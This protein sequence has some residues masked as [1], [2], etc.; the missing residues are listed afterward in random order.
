MG[1]ET[2]DAGKPVEHEKPDDKPTGEKPTDQ[3]PS[4]PEKPSVNTEWNVIDEDCWHK[5]WKGGRCEKQCGAGYCCSATKEHINGDC[6]ADAVQTMKNIGGRIANGGHRCVTPK[7]EGKKDDETNNPSEPEKPVEKPKP[8]PKKK[9]KFV[10]RATC[11]CKR[12]WSPALS[13]KNSEEYKALVAKIIEFFKAWF[14]KRGRSVSCRCTGSRRVSRGRRSLGEEDGVE[15]DIEVEGDVDEQNPN[16]M[17]DLQN[18]IKAAAEESEDLSGVSSIATEVK[19]VEVT[20]DAEEERQRQEDERLREEKERL[21]KEEER[22]REEKERQQQEK[23]SQLQKE[24]ERLRE[25]KERQQQEKERQEQQEGEVQP[26]WESWS[27]AECSAT[28]GDGTIT[29]TRKCSV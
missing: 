29:R 5:C 25:E 10:S 14:A 28:C 23:E 4:E 21:Q 26:S 24:E 1:S 15:A 6:P 13:D 20:D 22:L 16:E 19:E 18:N 12:K 2:E 3:K 7:E 17:A 9:K 8:K 11:P 27:D